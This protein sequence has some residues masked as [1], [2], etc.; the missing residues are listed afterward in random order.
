MSQGF[1][2][3]VNPLLPSRHDV[4]VVLDDL[5]IDVWFHFGGPDVVSAAAN[6]TPV[7]ASRQANGKLRQTSF[8]SPAGKVLVVA[9]C[10]R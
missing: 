4:A 6:G 3:N 8:F 10:N 9:F 1:L 2:H 5:R 7:V